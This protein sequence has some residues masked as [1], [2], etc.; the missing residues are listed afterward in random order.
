M[1]CE[2]SLDRRTLLISSMV[3]QGSTLRKYPLSSMPMPITPVMRSRDRTSPSSGTHPPHTPVLMAL[4]V[5]GL[6]LE[7]LTLMTS[8]SSDSSTGI[9]TCSPFPVIFDSS[10]RYLESLRILCL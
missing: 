3:V 8:L 7:L 9:M 1:R 5:T 6:P 2:K 4:T 10:V